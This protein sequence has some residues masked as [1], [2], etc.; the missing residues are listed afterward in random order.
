MKNKFCSETSDFF[1]TDRYTH[2]YKFVVGDMVGCTHQQK[3]GKTKMSIIIFC[4]N[5]P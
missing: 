3:D 2:R 4:F 1:I 5:F